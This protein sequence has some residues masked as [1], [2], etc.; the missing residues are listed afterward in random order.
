M[1]PRTPCTYCGYDTRGSRHCDGCEKRRDLA[2]GVRY[3]PGS[4]REALIPEFKGI[5]KEYVPVVVDHR[6]SRRPA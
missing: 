1:A 3:K 4:D 6:K 2:E 5:G